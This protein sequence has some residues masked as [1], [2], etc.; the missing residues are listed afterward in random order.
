MTITNIITAILGFCIG[1][2]AGTLLVATWNYKLFKE[3]NN[4]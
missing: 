1:G 2:M 4:E 3:E